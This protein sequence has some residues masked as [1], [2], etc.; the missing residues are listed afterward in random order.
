MNA[1]LPPGWIEA[2]WPG[3]P[4]VRGLFTARQGGCSGGPYGA[5]EGGGG[6]NLGSHVGDDPRAVAANRES[7]AQRLGGAV[8]AWLEQVHGCELADLDLDPGGPASP[9]RADASLLTRRGVAASVLVADC[10]PVLLAAPGGRGVAAAHAGWRGLAAGVLER[11]AAAL[12]ARCRCEPAQLQAWLGPAI[13]PAHFEVG[14]EV[15]EAFV[16]H[17]G[18]AQRAFMRG[19]RPGKWM[20]DLFELARMRLREA[21][22]AP[23]SMFGGGV[24]TVAN[25]SLY[26]SFRRD[27]V[28]GRQA[29]LVWLV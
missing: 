2:A 9:R 4:R 24:C 14:D 12:A 29:G 7:L 18:A 26:Y 13:G 6:M 15:R 10:L 3:N 22:L 5:G 16:A 25:P 8:P 17:H 28:T 21:G 23:E 1:R 19:E 27:R 11:S 20:A